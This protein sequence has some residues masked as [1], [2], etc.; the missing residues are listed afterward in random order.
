MVYVDSVT[1]YEEQKKIVH[2][3][4]K[5]LILRSIFILF[6]VKISKDS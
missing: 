5:W 4:K 3:A 2:I 1:F 6:L